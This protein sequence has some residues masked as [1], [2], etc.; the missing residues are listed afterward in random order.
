M[1]VL[2]HGLMNKFWEV[3]RDERSGV[4]VVLLHGLTN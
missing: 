4:I 2:L 3:L 1:V